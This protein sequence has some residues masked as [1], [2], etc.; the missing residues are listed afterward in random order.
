M[1]DITI[2]PARADDV[3][4]IAGLHAEDAVGGHGDVWSDE[5][6]PAYEAAFA[7]IAASPDIA[8]FVAEKE[9]AVVGAFQVCAIPGIAGRG[10]TRV[11]VEGVQVRRDL[12][13]AGIGAAM[14]AA[15][16]AW[17]Q[18]RGAAFLELTSNATRTDA[19]RFYA[20]LGYKQSHLGF[21]KKL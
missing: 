20:R 18:E 16:E 6:R 1:I 3:A 14:M 11:K 12:R 4:A 21:K 17:A 2:R 13:S 19:H 7:R 8:L 9:G 10:S 15:A 5:T